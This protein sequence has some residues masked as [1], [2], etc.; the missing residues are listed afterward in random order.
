MDTSIQTHWRAAWYHSELENGQISDLK[1]SF[2]SRYL[3]SFES[4]LAWGRDCYLLCGLFVGSRIASIQINA[5]QQ[6]WEVMPSQV[7]AEIRWTAAHH[8]K[9]NIVST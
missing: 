9:S 2:P 5:H 6:Y 3:L 7:R 8:D 4:I 1:V